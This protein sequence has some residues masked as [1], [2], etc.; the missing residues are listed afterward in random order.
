MAKIYELQPN[1]FAKF[2]PKIAQEL[3]DSISF[4][5]GSI[6]AQPMPVPFLFKTRHST[7]EPPSGLHG[8]I[9]P[10]MSDSF[11]KALQDAGA[12]N[13]Q[14]FPAEIRSKVDSSVWKNYKAVNIIGKIACADLDASESTHIIGRPGDDALP[15][16]AFEDL[17]VEP[18]RIGDALL[19]RLAESP[20]VILVAESVVEYL[21]TIQS[22]EDWGITLDER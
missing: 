20:G 7:K 16:M 8:R 12:S 14:C 21:R 15:L 3:S 17:K 1:I 6:I 11:I 22:D 10:V 4:K 5:S 19:F 9:I 13:L 18:T 2:V